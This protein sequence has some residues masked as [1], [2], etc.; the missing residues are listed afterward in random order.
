MTALEAPKGRKKKPC[1]PGSKK[2]KP[3]VKAEMKKEDQERFN[4]KKKR[5]AEEK[6]A[7]KE[8]K[9]I[10]HPKKPDKPKGAGPKS[11]SKPKGA[12]P[13]SPSKPKGAGPKNPEKPR[14]K[15]TGEDYLDK[16]PKAKQ[17][18]ADLRERL[19]KDKN[20]K[21]RYGKPMPYKI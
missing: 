16:K 1:P 6:K 14:N 17:G 2:S 18:W 4:R 21:D 5:I 9:V 10:A 13:K 15:R 12:G 20:R 7:R 19:K 11:P 3:K 8:G